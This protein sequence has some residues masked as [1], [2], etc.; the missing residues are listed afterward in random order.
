MSRILS[1]THA[2]SNPGMTASQLSCDAF[3]GNLVQQ[4]SNVNLLTS[5][6][7]ASVAFS[8][9]RFAAT[10]LLSSTLGGGTLRASSWSLAFLGEVT[11]FRSVHNIL[12][13]HAASSQTFS[14]T[15]LDLL[16]LK[17]AGLLCHPSHFITQHSLQATA[18]VGGSYLQE[19]LEIDSGNQGSISS[20]YAQAFATSIA[21]E[22]GGR[23]THQ[24][25]GSRLEAIQ[26]N[27]SN[28]ALMSSSIE[29]NPS[30]RSLASMASN[31]RIPELQAV[32]NKEPNDITREDLEVLFAHSDN[33][34]ALSL[35][36]E[37]AGLNV[38]RF[39]ERLILTRPDLFEVRHFLSTKNNCHFQ[40][41]PFLATLQKVLTERLKAEGLEDVAIEER[42]DLQ[43]YIFGN[44]RRPLRQFW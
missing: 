35:I 25:T 42:L 1:Q 14:S 15:A 5:M 22:I 10:G 43:P 3:Q 37:V 9:G 39:L 16:L 27:L 41:G 20:R 31:E 11:T 32:F 40:D 36:G 21:L 13:V 30:R 24:V 2:S 17:G 7:A 29:T 38:G 8:L 19:M 6:T 4:A 28:R 18:M 33:V 34:A 12:E 23:L 26:K 44:T